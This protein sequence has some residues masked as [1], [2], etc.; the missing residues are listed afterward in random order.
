MQ[1]VNY[2]SNLIYSTLISVF[3]GWKLVLKEGEF[4]LPLLVGFGIIGAAIVLRK[5][6]QLR[7]SAVLRE[8]HEDVLLALE[9]GNNQ[10]VDYELQYYPVPQSE[11]VRT[12]QR[13]RHFKDQDLKNKISDAIKVQVRRFKRTMPL[14]KSIGWLVPLLGLLGTIL[15]LMRAFPRSPLEWSDTMMVT[16]PDLNLALLNSAVGLTVGIPL[17]FFHSLLASKIGKYASIFEIFGHE[18]Y[19]AIKYGH[20][21][22]RQGIPDDEKSVD[23]SSSEP[24]EPSTGNNVTGG[25]EGESK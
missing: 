15:V 6:Y 14:L 16:G 24:A 22:R 3:E 17:L 23:Q 18:I 4:I 10:Q 1:F 19:L 5:F 8:D 25:R 20:R 9:R 2:L 12:A 11:I 7:Q 21:S 13:A